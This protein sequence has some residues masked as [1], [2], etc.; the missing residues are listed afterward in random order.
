M[1]YL[2]FYLDSSIYTDLNCRD[3]FLLLCSDK[4]MFTPM[5]IAC[6][7]GH[8]EIVQLLL[9]NEVEIKPDVL[10]TAL[11]HHQE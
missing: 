1:L 4:N 6:Q 11:E 8:D 9:D 5:Y 7:N 10:K 3:T 2:R